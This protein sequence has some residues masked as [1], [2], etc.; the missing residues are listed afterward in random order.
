[1]VLHAHL[2]DVVLDLEAQSSS[3]NTPM[4]HNRPKHL[5]L[6]L[7]HNT[8]FV[9]VVIIYIATQAATTFKAAQ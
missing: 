8:A 9:R 5:G 3:R 6:A 4:Q 7:R 2:D 1:M